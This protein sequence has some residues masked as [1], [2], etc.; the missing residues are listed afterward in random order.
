MELHFRGI[1]YELAPEMTDRATNKLTPL[2]KYL[3]AE[4]ALTQ[5]FVELG[6]SV[7]AHHTGQVWSASINLENL[8]RSYH[9]AEPRERGRSGYQ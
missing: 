1:N 9:A 4:D 5:V 2:K 6:K 8:G 7:G 3:R